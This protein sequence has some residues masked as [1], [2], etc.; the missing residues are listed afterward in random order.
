MSLHHIRTVR[1]HG[2]KPVM[3]CV[4]IGGTLGLDDGP[5]LVHV[6]C[7]P[8]AMDWTPMVGVWASV[9]R[10]NTSDKAIALETAACLEQAG[11]KLFGAT[12]ANG[13]YALTT[14]PDPD[15]ESLLRR[16][17]ELLWAA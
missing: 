9:H 4:V 14:I 8:R 1:L 2:G 3:V 6:T 10:H 16:E 15:R 13:A 17:R 7:N 5:T 11:A 12:D